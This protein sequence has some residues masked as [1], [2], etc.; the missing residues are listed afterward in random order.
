MTMYHGT[1]STNAQSILANGFQLSTDGT[2]GNGVYVS[3][4]VDKAKCYGHTILTVEVALGKSKKMDSL[5]DPLRYSW[6]AHGYDSAWIP[7][8]LNWGS[9]YTE[10]CVADPGR[11]RVVSMSATQD[12]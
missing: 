1:S 8:G 6:A 12:M 9:Q 2:V 11:I 7:A 10:T 5:G 3:A 4:D